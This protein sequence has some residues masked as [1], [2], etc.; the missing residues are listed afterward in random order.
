MKSLE[1]V[2]ALLQEKMESFRWRMLCKSS[3]YSIC[4]KGH[5]NKKDV[6]ANANH[7][8][9]MGHWHASEICQ[10]NSERGKA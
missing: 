5:S 10:L 4:R 8:N 1:E 3:F 6:N 2:T 9:K 7:F